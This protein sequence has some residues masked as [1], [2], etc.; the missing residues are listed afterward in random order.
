MDSVPYIKFK[1]TR[2][3]YE[4]L[5]ELMKGFNLKTP[6]KMAKM[7]ISA[8]CAR[9]ET[10]PPLGIPAAGTTHAR[11]PAV[12]DDDNDKLEQPIIASDSNDGSSGVSLNNVSR[13]RKTYAV[14]D[15]NCY[16]VY[17]T[18]K[19]G[20][21]M[22]VVDDE[23]LYYDAVDMNRDQWRDVTNEMTDFENGLLDAWVYGFEWM[24]PSYLEMLKDTNHLPTIEHYKDL[25]Q[26]YITSKE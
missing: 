16:P 1:P 7:I 25:L 24:F 5:K 20:I 6:G 26:R 10:S 11:T 8:A 2:E 9:H 3:E 19:S 22:C 15:G 14:R 17:A 23:V 21:R 4:R 13:V 18:K 12:I